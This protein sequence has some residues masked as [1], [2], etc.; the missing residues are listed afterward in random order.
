VVRITQICMEIEL[1]VQGY[2]CN[3][4]F[5]FRRCPR[6]LMIEVFSCYSYSSL[7]RCCSITWKWARTFTYQI[8]V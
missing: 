6:W 7:C 8:T 2:W 1:L 5:T 3:V 4:R